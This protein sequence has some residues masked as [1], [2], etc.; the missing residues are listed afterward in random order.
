MQ[1]PSS[2]F[3]NSSGLGLPK[4]HI[5]SYS[6]QKFHQVLFRFPPCGMIWDLSPGRNL[7]TI[8]THCACFLI[9]WLLVL[10]C[11]TVSLQEGKSSFWLY[12]YNG[13]RQNF[14]FLSSVSFHVFIQFLFMRT[15]AQFLPCW[16]IDR[17][18]EIEL[19]AQLL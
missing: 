10:Y 8:R 15:V 1:L 12:I 14:I 17:M 13:Q 7:G 5:F 2:C 19:N 6:T 11:L 9:S 18:I 4:L 3:V 16:G